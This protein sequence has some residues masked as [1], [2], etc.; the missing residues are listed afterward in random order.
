MICTD[1]GAAKID[2]AI[3]AVNI[4]QPTNPI[5]NIKKSRKNQ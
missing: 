2:P 3:E 4:P 1:G 5:K